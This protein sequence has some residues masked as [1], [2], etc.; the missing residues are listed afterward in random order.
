[1]LNGRHEGELI[2]RVPVS[3]L[4]WMVRE[5]HE[6]APLAAK[7]VLRRGTTL[8]RMDIS[9]HAIDRASTRLLRQWKKT[10]EKDEGLHHWLHRIACAAWDGRD[11][12]NPDQTVFK[13]GGIRFVFEVTGK[14]PALKTVMQDEKGRDASANQRIRRGVDA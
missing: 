8:S 9:G 1:M 10:R 13:R 14:W 5:G 3:Y 7:E 12:S 2:T 6:Q 4:N 11:Q